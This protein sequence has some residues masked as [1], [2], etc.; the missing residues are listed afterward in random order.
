MV[1]ARS[2]RL[3]T[4][5]SRRVIVVPPARVT[6]R[7]MERGAD[8]H[9]CAHTRLLTWCARS[10]A[11]MAAVRPRWRRMEE[12]AER[13][14]AARWRRRLPAC[15]ISPSGRAMRPP[16]ASRTA[17]IRSVIIDLTAFR[18]ELR[19]AVTS[20]SAA[21][22]H[23]DYSASDDQAQRDQ[24]HHGSIGACDHVG[25]ISR[26]GG[27][28][29]LN[30]GFHRAIGEVK[31]RPGSIVAPR[32]PAPLG[33]RSHCP[34]GSTSLFGALPRPPAAMPAASSV[35]VLIICGVGTR[36]HELTSARG[37]AVGFAPPAC[38]RH[39]R[40]LLRRAKELSDRICRDGVGVRVEGHAI[41][42]IGRAGTASRR[43]RHR[44]RPARRR[45]R[46]VIGLRMDNIRP[47]WGEGRHGRR[48]WSHRINPGTP[49]ERTAPMSEG[50]S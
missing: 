27:G 5:C 41:N 35:Y 17:A 24:L 8:P 34:R 29:A 13:F 50:T 10:S 32:E 18:E 1:L 45:R 46:A 23:A 20:K 21:R 33:M 31:T 30:G 28:V 4:T 47:A 25:L 37:F 44:A 7:R 2:R 42:M 3:Q 14:G 11:I 15:W 39:R 9:L 40:R 22:H 26:V 49:D 19:V 38:R 48:P 12:I 36:P 16:S 43:L 6:R